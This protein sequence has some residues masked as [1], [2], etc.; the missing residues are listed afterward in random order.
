MYKNLE[1]INFKLQSSFTMAM[2]CWGKRFPLSF[3]FKIQV[4]FFEKYWEPDS[5][6]RD[7]T[8]SVLSEM[9]GG[10]VYAQA[11]IG[12]SLTNLQSVLIAKLKWF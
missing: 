11:T 3:K 7:T 10:G 8:V 5:S 4:F 1:L 2:N 6:S 9:G 12:S